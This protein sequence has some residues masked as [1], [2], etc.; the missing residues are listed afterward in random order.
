MTKFIPSF[1]NKM[2]KENFENILLSELGYQIHFLKRFIT[3][4]VNLCVSVITYTKTSI[5]FKIN[6][7]QTNNDS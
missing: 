1:N 5:V 2:K 7:A 3:D 4:E 6:F